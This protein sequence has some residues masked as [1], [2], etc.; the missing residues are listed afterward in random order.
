MCLGLDID[1]LEKVRLNGKNGKAA[2]MIKI[3]S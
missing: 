3:K 2:K 1:Q